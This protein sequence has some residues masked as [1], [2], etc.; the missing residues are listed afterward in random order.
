MELALIPSGVM[1]AGSIF[2]VLL[3]EPPPKMI[4]HALQHLAAGIVLCAIS[5]ELVSSI[6]PLSQADDSQSIIGLILGFCLGVATMISLSIFL[7]PDEDEEAP[8]SEPEG[9]DEQ[10]PLMRNSDADFVNDDA[11][12]NDYSDRTA[13]EMELRCVG[14]AAVPQGRCVYID[15]VMD[16]LL[17]GISLIAGKSAGLFMAVALCVEMGFLGLTF[18][19]ACTGQPKYRAVPAV[20]AGPLFLMCGSCIGGLLANAL[21]ANLAALIACTSFGVAALLYMVCEE[22]L[23]SA[24]EEG[25]EHVWWVDLQV[26]VGFLLA[27]LLD[28]AVQRKGT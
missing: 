28:K 6:P 5:T 12:L 11:P 22:L 7:E 2:T 9:I 16:G 27:L 20:V 23:V 4:A 3:P 13:G 15:S 21:A 10:E 18:A 8:I 1:L 25:D 24:H 17:V 14:R 26:F 19:A